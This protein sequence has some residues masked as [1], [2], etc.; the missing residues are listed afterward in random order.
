[1]QGFGVF[2]GDK[3]SAYTGHFENNVKNGY[4]VYEWLEKDKVY[5]G[6][7]QNG[8]QH[9]LGTLT[10]A[11]TDKK[12]GLWLNGTRKLYLDEADTSSNW[13]NKI[14]EEQKKEFVA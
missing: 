4:G 11:K 6:Y 2:K 9:G 3:K 1:M 8:K 14:S 13:M 10:T 12:F 7:W 5:A